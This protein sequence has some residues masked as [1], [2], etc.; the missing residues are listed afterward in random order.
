[1]LT[2]EYK[3]SALEDLKNMTAEKMIEVLTAIGSVRKS[4]SEAHSIELSVNVNF[5]SQMTANVFARSNISVR[6]EMSEC[7]F[8]N[9]NI[10]GRTPMNIKYSKE[11]SIAA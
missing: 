1:M 7:R 8:K 10:I 6:F 11:V 9:N 4:E 3:K 5:M 2:D